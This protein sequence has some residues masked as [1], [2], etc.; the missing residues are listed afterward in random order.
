MSTSISIKELKELDPSSY[1]I[2]DIRD[3]VEISHGAI[4]GALVMKTEEIETSDA[5][6]RSKKTIICCSRGRFSV[7]AAEELQEKGWDAVSLEGGYI[8]WLMD[9]M[10]APEEQDKAA[11]VEKSLRKKFKKSIWSKFTKAINTYELVKPGDKIAVCISGGKDSMLMAKCFQEL[12]KYSEIHFDVK[13]VVMDP[14][15]SKENRLIIEDNAKKLNI[16]IEIFETDIFENVFHI[17]KN[18]CYICARMRRGHLY[19]YAK[20]IGCNKIALGHHFDDVIET[21]VMSML[22]GAQI[23]TMMPKLHSNHFEGMEVIRP[24]Y[25][26]REDDIK[27][28][29]KHNNLYFIQCAC[30]FTDTCSSEACLTRPRSKRVEVKNLIRDLKKTNP[31]VEQNIFKSVENVSLKTIIAYKDDK[32]KHHFL[33]TYDDVK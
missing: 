12:H 13:F 25:L 5:I 15:Y 17:D 32:E 3:A 19:N 20:N 16:P 1:Q 4:P 33:D 24:L 14:G 27:A 8:A 29:A 10:S 30:K 26:V 18:P 9:V 23:Q 7:A 2:V 11:D 31:Y 21:I 28:W 6:D 22:Y